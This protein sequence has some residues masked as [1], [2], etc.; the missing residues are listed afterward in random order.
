MSTETNAHG[1]N[2]FL[3]TKQ[4]VAKVKESKPDRTGILVYHYL[5]KP[6]IKLTYHSADRSFNH[7]YFN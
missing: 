6:D 3:F 4:Q 5:I 7:F 2:L 1:R